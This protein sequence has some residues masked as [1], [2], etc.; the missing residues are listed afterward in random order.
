MKANPITVPYH[1]RQFSLAPKQQGQPKIKFV[2]PNTDNYDRNIRYAGELHKKGIPTIKQDE[3][4]G[5]T[6]I[7]CGSGNTIRDPEVIE[8][9]D[10]YLKEGALLVPCKQSIKIFHDKNY[11]IDYGVTMDPGAHIACAEKIYKAPGMTHIVAS[12]SDPK[13]WE[14]LDGENIKIFHSATGYENEVKLYKE[15]FDNPDCMGGGYNVCNRAISAFLYMGCERIICAGMDSGWRDGD[16][17]YAD[18]TNNRPGVDMKDNGAV[19]GINW[20]TRPDM[21]ASG[22]A[23]AKLAKK[24]GPDRFII[25]GK[26]MPFALKEKDDKFLNDCVSFRQD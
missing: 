25:L 13:L 17:F 21:L 3:L 18:D 15:L 7:I 14:Y 19:D 20:N 6:A 22:V 16:T 10:N 11:K 12:S 24:Y 1:L 5:Q 2:N 26:T 9:I 4:K 8:A 23:I